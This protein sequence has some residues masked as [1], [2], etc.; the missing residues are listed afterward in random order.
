MH[1]SQQRDAY[2]VYTMRDMY[3]GY[4]LHASWDITVCIYGGD[5]L[6]LISEVI[7]L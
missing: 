2:C 5:A 4:I 3:I 1:K 6:V 7:T